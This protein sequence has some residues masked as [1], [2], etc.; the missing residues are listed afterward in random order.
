MNTKY[1]EF[2]YKVQWVVSAGRQWNYGD[3]Q[4]P[5]S[6]GKIRQFKEAES[7]LGLFGLEFLVRRIQYLRQ[8]RLELANLIFAIN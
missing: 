7:V 3:Y 8:I 2:E 4:C 1:N 6:K 5:L